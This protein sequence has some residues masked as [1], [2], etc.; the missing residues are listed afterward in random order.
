MNTPALVEIGRLGKLEADGFYH[1]QFE[2]ADRDILNQLTE[3]YLIFDSNRVFFVTVEDKKSVGNRIYLKFLEDGID[4]EYRKPG[5]TAI[6]L[7]EDDLDDFTEDDVS[8]LF[9]YEVSF[10]GDIIGKVEAAIINPLQAV[11][12]IRL[13]DGRELMVPSVSQFVASVDSQ[14]KI[15]WMQNLEQLLE[16]CTSAS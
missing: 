7:E 5:Q 4:A 11:L 6:A 2:Q 15:V 14:K 1:I 10:E 12:I 8:D 3:C 13:Q 9:G 16:I